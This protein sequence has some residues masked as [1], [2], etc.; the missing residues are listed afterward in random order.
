MEELLKAYAKKRQ[1]EAGAPFELHPATRRLLQGE[2]ARLRAQPPSGATWRRLFTGLAPRLAVACSLLL[3]LGV[4]LWPYRPGQRSSQPFDIALASPTAAPDGPAIS[5]NSFF[6]SRLPAIIPPPA[7]SKPTTLAPERITLAESAPTPPAPSPGQQNELLKLSAAPAPLAPPAGVSD[8]F[9]LLASERT[10]EAKTLAQNSPQLSVKN[11]ARSKVDRSFT[12]PLADAAPR[13]D[14][15]IQSRSLTLETQNGVSALLTV[16]TA[17]PSAPPSIQLQYAIASTPTAPA[18]LRPS[19]AP[20]ALA[21]STGP[22]DSAQFA[23]ARSQQFRRTPNAQDRKSKDA[24]AV[25]DRVLSTFDFSQSGDLI[26]IVDADGSVYEGHVIASNPVTLNQRPTGALTLQSADPA[27]VPFLVSGTNRT[28]NQP[29]F[30]EGFLNTAPS[31]APPASEPPAPAARAAA[32]QAQPAPPATPRATGA[33]MST[34]DKA[35]PRPLPAL[36]IQGNARIGTAAPVPIDAR[37]TA[38]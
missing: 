12:T 21:A 3:V 17:V 23:S 10:E 4:V 32:P 30:F 16:Q 31:S 29:L 24:A 33:I 13:F 8:S 20:S 15:A 27:T 35:A 25:A 34:L 22:T 7:R 28:A 6:Q 14:P 9:T 19:A 37:S 5:T 1:D 2:V 11:R 38:P 36:R 26:R 18:E